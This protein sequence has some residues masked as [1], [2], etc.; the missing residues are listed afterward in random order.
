MTATRRST[1][2]GPDGQPIEVPLLTGEIAAPQQFGQRALVYYT[3]ATGLTPERLAEVLKSANHGLARP[4]LTLAIDMEERY[5]HYASQLQ[6]RRLALDGV[7]ISVSAPKGCNPKAV[8][9]VQS[10]VDAP[11]FRDMVMDLQDGLSKGY[12]V[13]EPVWEFENGALR[14]VQ[15]C[16]RDPRYF[17]YDMVGL[18]TLHLLDESGLPG[19]E[20]KPPY[21]IKHEPKVRA[22]I[23]VRR[24]LARL[25]AWSFMIQSY[26]LQDWAAF[27]EIYGIPLRVGKYGPSATP[28]DKRVLLNA[29]RSISNDAAAII[30]SSMEIDF[31][32][33]SGTRGEQ[34]F[35][36]LIEYVDR[37]VS[38]AV[39]GQTMTSENGSSL[40]QAKVHNEVR[41]DIQRSDARQTAA[42]LNRDLVEPLV[43]MNFGPQ[44]VYPQVQLEIAEAEDLKALGEFLKTAVPLGLKVGQSYVRKKASIPEPDDED[45]LLGAPEPEPEAPTPPA[46]KPPKQPPA[47]EPEPKPPTSEAARLALGH[48]V[49]C[50]CPGCGSPTTRFAADDPNAITAIDDVDVIVHDAMADWQ[51][52]T[53]PLLAGL[54]S[55]VAGATDFADALKRI[56]GAKIDTEKLTHALA[57]AGM[58]SR[59]LGDVRD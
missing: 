8:D 58:K 39:I 26:A 46:P 28:A 41:H 17:R 16:H 42:T 3:E 45:E 27:A 30:P 37:K 1:I 14:P 35:G 11:E 23:P 43:A 2:L 57:V 7:T 47:P 21:F 59:G 22:G 53:D 38:L 4:Y 48:G 18:T 40:G 31:Q 51:E 6:T 33:V 25:A 24:G 54:L 20:I 9:L 56:E 19:L 32:E 29:V 5:L 13:I 15:H 52:V 12:S 36:N 55:A 50:M 10:V 49:G 34:V 44:D